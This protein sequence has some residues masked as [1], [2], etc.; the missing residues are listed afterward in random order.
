V[1]LVGGGFRGDPFEDLREVRIAEIRYDDTDRPAA[2]AQQR[3]GGRVRPVAD[4]PGGR[5]DPLGDLRRHRLAAAE[6]PRHGRRRHLGQPR[7]IV[8]RGAG[9]G[10]RWRLSHG[11]I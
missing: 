3:L 10:L 6:H 1:V 7:H 5:A 4:V 11:P 8:D 9:C 2:A